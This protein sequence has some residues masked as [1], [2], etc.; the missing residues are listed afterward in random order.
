MK[1]TKTWLAAL[2]PLALYTLPAGAQAQAADRVAEGIRH[3]EA[4]RHA[5][6]RAVLEEAARSTPTDARAPYYLG[7]IAYAGQE[8]GKASDWF[9][10]AV[11]QEEGNA[12]YHLWL[13]R[14]YG[15]EAQ[16][17]NAVRQA[18][19]AKRIKGEF[20]RAVALDPSN[21]EA[22]YD[23]M[24]YY[25]VAPGVMGGSKEKARAA[26]EEVR[27]RSAWLGY[28]AW[29]QI[30]QNE[31][32]AAG[33]EREL[34]TGIRTFPDSAQPYLGLG[35]LYQQS[36][37]YGKAFDLYEELVA[38]RVGEKSALYQIGRA[39]AISGERLERGEEALKAYLQSAGPKD[40]MR[41]GAHWR[42]GMIHER[43]GKTDFARQQYE[44]AL[45]VDPKHKEA[46]E[47]LKKLR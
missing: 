12:L 36:G 14:S 25:L 3:F 34:R 11:K 30:Y 40:A 8:W 39:A 37:E 47:A 26:A 45:A 29:V 32:D 4:G 24:T 5:E 6:A 35:T 9:G 23:L 20:E 41:A 44:A 31:K 43:Q 18:V 27:K 28:Q 38:R 15:A 46:K 19:L 17:T 42:L 1:L 22:H 16:R 10:K 2:L 13:G 7:R 21:A 33:A